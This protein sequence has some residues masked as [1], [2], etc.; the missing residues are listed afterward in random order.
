MASIP[1]GDS[2]PR[3]TPPPEVGMIDPQKGQLSNAGTV[4]LDVPVKR[5]TPDRAVSGPGYEVPEGGIVE[6]SPLSNNTVDVFF[7]TVGPDA[8]T[9][10]GA[11]TKLITTALPRRVRV[12][13]L[14]DIWVYSANVGE[15]VNM[16]VLLN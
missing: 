7:S 14:S 12:R 13:N 2:N 10:T 11:R 16:T 5:Q 9:G 15:G 1:E 8:V 6:I 3:E 4:T